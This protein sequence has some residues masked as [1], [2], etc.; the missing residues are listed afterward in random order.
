MATINLVHVV[1]AVEFVAEAMVE[2]PDDDRVPAADGVEPEQFDT[3]TET[4]ERANA[5]GTQ[6]GDGL[7][8]PR[9]SGAG[10]WAMHPW[11]GS[12]AHTGPAMPWPA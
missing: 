4:I 11:L 9:L 8:V 1:G 2:Q 5:I 10:C 6:P 3:L 12:P 7:G